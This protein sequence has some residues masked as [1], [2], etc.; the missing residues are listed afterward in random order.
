VQDDAQDDAERAALERLAFGRPENRKGEKAARKAQKKLIAE[1]AEEEA[2]P[3]RAAA[4]P[5]PSLAAGLPPAAPRSAIPSPAGDEPIVQEPLTLDATSDSGGPRFARPRTRAQYGAALAI[6]LIVGAVVGGGVTQAIIQ[7]R[8]I[9]ASEIQPAPGHGNVAA[10]EKYFAGVQTEVDNFPEP[11]WLKPLGILDSS[12]HAVQTSGSGA[13]LWIGK[14]ENTLCLIWSGNNNGTPSLETSC[15]TREAFA[16][17]GLTLVHGD[18]VYG[19]DG[20]T[21]RTT[22]NEN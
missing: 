1:D 11:Q 22:T 2:T 13:E 9:P 8:P 5:A 10:A 12:T 14:T 15:G 18:E 3:A 20:L 7:G 16:K 21:F 19:W 6:A 4:S 17:S